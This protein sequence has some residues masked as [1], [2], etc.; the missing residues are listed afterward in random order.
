M[1]IPADP[2]YLNQPNYSLPSELSSGFSYLWPGVFHISL[3]TLKMHNWGGGGRKEE[4]II[5][6]GLAPSARWRCLWHF[7]VALCEFAGYRER[8]IRAKLHKPQG[9]LTRLLALVNPASVDQQVLAAAFLTSVDWSPLCPT[10]IS[11]LTFSW[12]LSLSLSPA[13]CSLLL[14]SADCFSVTFLPSS[15]SGLVGDLAGRTFVWV[16]RQNRQRDSLTGTHTQR[17]ECHPSVQ[18]F[19]FSCKYIEIN[20]SF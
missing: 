18:S 3:P 16:S 11:W 10:L 15:S 4:Q 17:N 13:D 14:P 19:G 2:H 8:C 6:L 20:N 5:G 7:C 1:T 12:L 9:I